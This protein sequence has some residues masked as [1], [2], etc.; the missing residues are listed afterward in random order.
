ML[1]EV[2]EAKIRLSH[3]CNKKCP[4][5]SKKCATIASNSICQEYN[6]EYTCLSTFCTF[7]DFGNEYIYD[8]GHF[9]SK[10]I[11]ISKC[12]LKNGLKGVHLI[13]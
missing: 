3:L 6:L 8:R 1:L 5:V 4:K 13:W 12:F 10:T 11:K 9:N 7:Q 2:D